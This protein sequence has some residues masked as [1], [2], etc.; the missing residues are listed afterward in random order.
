MRIS[1]WSSDVCSSD[2]AETLPEGDGVGVEAPVRRAERE[3]ERTLELAGGLPGVVR[4]LH[5]QAVH[6]GGQLVALIVDGLDADVGASLRARSE[7][8][9]VGKECGRTCQSG[10]GAYH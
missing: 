3:T 10:W 8:R 2:L 9:R 4:R 7:E 1:D 5:T 6:A